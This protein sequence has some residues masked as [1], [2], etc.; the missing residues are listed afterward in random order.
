MC[1]VMKQHAY[2]VCIMGNEI[3]TLYVGVTNNLIRRLWEYKNNF[4]KACFVIK[5][6]GHKLLYFQHPT[7]IN[8]AI[9]REKQLK[10]WH[11]DWKINLIKKTNPALSDLS[12]MF[13]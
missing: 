3:P 11:R 6:K 8:S 10:R 9:A 7:D 1:K 5:Y 4:D 13:D 2:Y 12:Q